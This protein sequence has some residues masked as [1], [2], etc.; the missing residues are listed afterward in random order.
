MKS[1]LNPYLSFKG[2]T[3]EAM[4]FYKSVFG[5]ELTITTFAD[6]QVPNAPADGVMH[7]QLAVDGK[8]ILMG[9]DGM[10]SKELQGF[11][12][13]LSGEAGDELRDYFEK[14]SERGTITKPLE[15]ESWGDEFGMVVD[16]FGIMWMVNISTPRAA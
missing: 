15:K 10:D 4:E 8:P 2:K 11:S 9:S 6:Q 3:R 1:M 14:L 13:S 5:G 7:A 12:L 16:K